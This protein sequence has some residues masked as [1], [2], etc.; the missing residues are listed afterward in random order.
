MRAAGLP[1]GPSMR[2]SRI[3]GLA[4]IVED[5]V[6]KLPDRGSFAGSVAT[7]DR[8]VRTMIRQAGVSLPD[9]IMMITSTPA[10]IM[11]IESKGSLQDGMDADIVI[12]DDQISIGKTIIGGRVVYDATPSTSR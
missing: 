7:A 10:R 9:A 4:V 5:E 3:H 12:F 11:K 2:G 6:A 1:P 8:L